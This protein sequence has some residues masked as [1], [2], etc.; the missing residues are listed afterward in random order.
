MTQSLNLNKKL[1]VLEIGTEVGINLTY[2]QS[3]QDLFIQLKDIV[4]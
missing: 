4:A 1:R 3:C 2:Y